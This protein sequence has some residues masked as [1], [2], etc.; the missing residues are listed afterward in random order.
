[1]GGPVGE[2]PGHPVTGSDEVVHGGGQV[3]EGG[4]EAGPEGA[5]GFAAIGDEG[6]VV[7]V[8]GGHEAV[9]GVGVVLVEH[10]QVALGE[11]LVVSG[12]GRL[13]SFLATLA[14]LAAICL[15]ALPYL[16]TL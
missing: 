9:D 4:E 16:G 2:A 14:L 3:G 5:V 1:V 11:L 7:D 13:L 15:A 10:G 6:V 8:A 12:H